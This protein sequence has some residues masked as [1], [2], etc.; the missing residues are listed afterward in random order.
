MSEPIIYIFPLKIGV[1]SQDGTYVRDTLKCVSKT[2]YDL[3][4]AEA[5]KLAEAL[6]I[7]A[8][9]NDIFPEYGTVARDT[10]KQW[11]AFLELTNK[12]NEK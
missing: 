10:L 3:L 9:T 8:S 2:D 5:V 11:Q 1:A 4:L 7:Y 12:E 6:E